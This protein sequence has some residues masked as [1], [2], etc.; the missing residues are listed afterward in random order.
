MNTMISTPIGKP[1]I[2]QITKNYEWTNERK[3]NG[4]N[5]EVNQ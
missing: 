1:G 4:R 3:D 2:K 5:K